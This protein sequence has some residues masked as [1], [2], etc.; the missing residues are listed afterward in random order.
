MS[1]SL[2]EIMYSPLTEEDD[3][4]LAG[5]NK[6]TVEYAIQNKGRIMS[7]MRGIAMK[8]H[9]R[10]IQKADVEDMFSDLI[11]YLYDHDDYNLDKAIDRSSNGTI[12]GI[13][14]YVFSCA[15]FCTSRFCKDLNY[16]ANNIV[17]E[18]TMSDSDTELSIFNSIADTKAEINIDSIIYDL[19]TLCKGC[20]PMRYKFGPDI[21]LV[22]FVR[23][24]TAGP[25]QDSIFRGT[26]EV[27][28]ISNREL[29][30]L[31]Q[32]NENTIMLSLAKAVNISGI[33][34][35]LK[36]FKKYVYAADMIEK[37]VYSQIA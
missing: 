37:T 5:W 21:Y 4:E 2:E 7:T 25:N 15:K 27:L 32:Y 9:S 28:G 26:L 35:A 23:L 6:E 22:W 33:P 36:I 3:S 12:V 17:G 8:N 20:E 19:S 29:A 1:Q 31:E 13:E 16:R 11:M 24:L 30:Q 14:G 34:E 10:G 18:T